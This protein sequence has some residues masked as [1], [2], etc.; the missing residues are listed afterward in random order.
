MAITHPKL[1]QYCIED[2]GMGKVLDYIS[3]PY[4]ICGEFIT[5]KGH[6]LNGKEY[7][8]LKFM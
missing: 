2:L 4:E 5:E 8:Q 1:Y 7:N 3:V 6:D